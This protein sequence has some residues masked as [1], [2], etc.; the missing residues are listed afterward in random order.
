MP[1]N[2]GAC[3]SLRSFRARNPLAKRF[4]AEAPPYF[5]SEALAVGC[6]TLA[7]VRRVES[8]D[9][10]WPWAFATRSEMMCFQ[11]N[12]QPGREPAP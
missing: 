8:G 10:G 2:L 12:G 9:S 7:R 6:S 11:R 5:Q 4:Q 3:T 1:V